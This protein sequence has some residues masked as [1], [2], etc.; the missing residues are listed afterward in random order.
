MKEAVS[1]DPR[2]VAR[3]NQIR[4]DLMESNIMKTFAANAPSHRHA[5]P[6]MRRLNNMAPSNSTS[7]RRLGGSGNHSEDEE[8]D[9]ESVGDG[10]RPES[11]ISA[12][13]T[14]MPIFINMPNRPDIRQPRSTAEM[15]AMEHKTSLRERGSVLVPSLLAAMRE[16]GIQSP[17]DSES[18]GPSAPRQVS[19]SFAQRRNSRSVSGTRDRERVKQFKADPG[20]VFEAMADDVADEEEDDGAGEAAGEDSGTLRDSRTFVPPHVLARKESLNSKDVGWRSMVNE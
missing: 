2:F 18:A 14:S 3:A 15:P 8:D 16:R 11:S 9:N 4:R 6:E 12:L 17:G 13:A 7:T 5:W 19:G 20:A 1:Q 10:D